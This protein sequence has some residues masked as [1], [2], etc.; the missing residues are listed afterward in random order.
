MRLSAIVFAPALLAVAVLPASA[1]EKKDAAPSSTYKVEFRIK[2]GTDATAKNGRRYAM[3]IDTTGHG[4]FHVSDRVPVASGLN[5]F[6]YYDAGVNIDTRLRDVQGKVAL[7]ATIELTFV[8]NKA[9]GSSVS[10]EPTLSQIKIVVNAT[11]APGSPTLVSS[12]DDPAMERKFDV[13][14]L[15]TKVD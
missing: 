7:D 5:Q 9:G 4:A 3:L 10:S 1:Q 14:A 8:Q 13:E 2:N 12:I 15:V 11:V 6:T